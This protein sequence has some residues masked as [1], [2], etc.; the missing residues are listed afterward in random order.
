MKRGMLTAI[1][2]P[3]GGRTEF[4]YEA[5]RYLDESNTVQLAGGLRIRQIRDVESDGSVMY[6]NFR[7]STAE[8]SVNGAGLLNVIPAGGS[9]SAWYPKDSLM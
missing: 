2:Y 9:S 8:D 7:Y 6:R 5:H 3:T 1:T 4:S